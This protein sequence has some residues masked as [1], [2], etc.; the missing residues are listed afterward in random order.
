MDTDLDSHLCY[1]IFYI[2]L[3]RIRS[4]IHIHNYDDKTNP[5][6][7]GNIIGIGTRLSLPS[8]IQKA[9]SKT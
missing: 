8:I 9:S 1:Y 4:R 5:D 7:E 2:S 6:P 3:E